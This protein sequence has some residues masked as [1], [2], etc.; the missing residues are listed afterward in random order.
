MY[1]GRRGLLWSLDIHKHFKEILPLPLSKQA[2]E[3]QNSKLS[4]RIESRNFEDISHTLQRAFTSQF[5]LH[6]SPF[7]FTLV[8]RAGSSQNSLFL[9]SLEQVLRCFDSADAARRGVACG[10]ASTL[11]VAL[12]VEPVLKGKHKRF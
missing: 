9:L 12:S 6:R 5:R 10:G 8:A 2:P 1:V 7:T 11:E 4:F 3:A